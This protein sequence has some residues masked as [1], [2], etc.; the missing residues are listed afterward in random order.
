MLTSTNVIAGQAELCT[1]GA[2]R[3]PDGRSSIPA[4]CFRQS[5]WVASVGNKI[6]RAMAYEYVAAADA[7]QMMYAAAPNT[8]AADAVKRIAAALA[9]VHQEFPA[10]ADAAS[11][12]D[13]Y[14]KIISTYTVF[15]STTGIP[16]KE[17]LV[18][19]L[20]W[21]QSGSTVWADASADMAPNA[22][23][24]ITA[25][26]LLQSVHAALNTAY[27]AAQANANLKAVLQDALTPISTL[28]LDADVN[29]IIAQDAS[30]AN[31]NYI[32][33]LALQF[34]QGS[35][36]LNIPDLVGESARTVDTAR[37]Q[38]TAGMGQLDKI[39]AA[40]SP[41]VA[42]DPNSPEAQQLRKEVQQYVG[43]A[44]AA[45]ENVQSVV[46]VVGSLA[47]LIDQNIGARINAVG[48]GIGELVRDV[49][50]C[51]NTAVEI[52]SAVIGFA[53][54]LATGNIVGAVGGLLGFFDGGGPSQTEQAMIDQMKQLQQQLTGLQRHLDARLDR[55]DAELDKIFTVMND[56]LNNIAADIRVIRTELAMLT[57]ALNRLETELNAYVTYDVYRNL[58]L[59]LALLNGVDPIGQW[60]AIEANL[61]LWATDDFLGP[62]QAGLPTPARSYSDDKVLSEITSATLE[63]N[64]NYL[65]DYPAQALG[66]P[67]VSPKRLGN[68]RDWVT[69]TL[70]YF[71][72]I[73]LGGSF[74]ERRLRDI[75]AAG[76]QLN[77]QITSMGAAAT[78][79]DD[80]RSDMTS[81]VYLRLFDKYW[82]ILDR[83]TASS[84]SVVTELM[85]ARLSGL[86]GFLASSANRPI[87]VSELSPVS[88]PRTIAL[89][90][91]GWGRPYVSDQGPIQADRQFFLRRFHV[92][93]ESRPDIELVPSA[94][95]RFD[96]V[97]YRAQAFGIGRLDMCYDASF[98]ANQGDPSDCWPPGTQCV[99]LNV[100][101]RSAF[102][103]AN[104]QRMRLAQYTRAFDNV[105]PS[106]DL[107]F[108]GPPSPPTPEATFENMLKSLLGWFSPFIKNEISEAE[109]N[110][111]LNSL[112]AAEE[113][114]L[115]SLQREF[116]AYVFGNPP[117]ASSGAL[118]H[119]VTDARQALTELTGIK[120]LLAAYVH[121]GMP[122]LLEKNDL[123]RAAFYGSDG[124]VDARIAVQQVVPAQFPLRLDPLQKLKAHAAKHIE[125]VHAQLRKATEGG[126]SAGQSLLR[127]TVKQLQMICPSC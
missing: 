22:R 121:T 101:L 4:H 81:R 96:N 77:Q 54:S 43:E 91:D 28:S 21:S 73:T 113:N 53:A 58:K 17:L 118:A 6:H 56:R 68:S 57:A 84:T 62:V 49:A 52:G 98:S 14:E 26:S 120:Q 44:Q 29:A 115:S 109:Q 116:I 51:A 75:Y 117:P 124:I 66:L 8:P 31:S 63:R 76:S 25:S 11:A 94:M 82:R 32:R 3:S 5:L 64:I 126:R 69:A 125:V 127:A 106:G 13:A 12:A 2:F 55:I 78:A 70:A 87:G 27:I 93:S 79:K 61:Y 47:S 41:L 111:T 50:N 65:N 72:G 42:Y 37:S 19:S 15:A 7:L 46:Y 114:T 90:L 122:A 36:T 108:P 107:V 110:M 85:Q 67:P 39:D 35:A 24:Y 40:Q 59:Q 97:V 71:H 86:S 112:R 10:S 80:E 95:L 60:P 103:L 119:H 30:L 89:Q 100:I 1:P 23:V 48:D 16:R 104:G 20:R 99:R 45:A 88:D 74:Q 38:L 123:A 9:T 102:V 18:Q 92:C 33:Q 34:A 83:F 105:Q